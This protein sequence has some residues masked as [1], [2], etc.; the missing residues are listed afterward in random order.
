MNGLWETK[1]HTTSYRALLREELSQI[2]SEAGFSN[3]T[4]NMPE[5]T[6]YYQPILIAEK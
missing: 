6:G 5:D 3:I 2:L 4:W 1:H